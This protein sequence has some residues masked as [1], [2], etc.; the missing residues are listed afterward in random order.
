MSFML[1]ILAFVAATALVMMA[2]HMNKGVVPHAEAG[3]GHG[4]GHDDDDNHGHSG[5]HH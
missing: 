4:G 2:L 5:G 3:H 1:W